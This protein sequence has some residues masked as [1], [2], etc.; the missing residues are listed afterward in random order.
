[1]FI[2]CELFVKNYA[3]SKMMK[4]QNWILFQRMIYKP[5]LL[6]FRKIIVWSDDTM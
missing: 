4:A 2:V 3:R 1:M 6:Y 5:C